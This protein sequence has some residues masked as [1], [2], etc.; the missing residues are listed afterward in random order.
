MNEKHI[1]E[2]FENY[3]NI[4]E[5]ISGLKEILD[6]NLLENN[7]YHKLGMDNLKAL[8]DNIIELM[9]YTYSPRKVRIRIR[10]IEYDE[11]EAK[12]MFPFKLLT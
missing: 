5:C 9:N 11:K 7:I 1:D 8:H 12:K 3:N 6:I 2:A 4:R 10:E